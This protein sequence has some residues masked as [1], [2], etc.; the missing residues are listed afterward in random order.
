MRLL[1]VFSAVTST[2]F[3]VIRPAEA[4]E[5]RSDFPSV[6]VQLE[7]TTTRLKG[8]LVSLDPDTVTLIVKD[9]QTSLPLSRVVRITVR[10][11]DSVRNGAII[12]AVIGGA[13]CA[14]TCGQGLNSGG[15]LP[16]AVALSAGVWSLAGAGIDASHRREEVLYERAP[17]P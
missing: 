8:R 9:H 1:A 7:N 6:I 3:V 17:T 5:K 11:G 4:Q 14:R 13:L 2:I 15:E 12:G 16:L 10:R